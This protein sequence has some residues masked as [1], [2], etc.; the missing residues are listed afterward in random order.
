MASWLNLILTFRSF[1]L[2]RW[3]VRRSVV[4]SGVVRS[5]SVRSMFDIRCSTFSMFDVFDVLS[6]VR[7]VNEDN[8]EYK[9]Y[10]EEVRNTCKGGRSS[11]FLN[12]V[13]N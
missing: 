6:S 4:R 12:E 11:D 13:V 2:I 3:F 9:R 1:D 5:G 7:L 10:P 8:H